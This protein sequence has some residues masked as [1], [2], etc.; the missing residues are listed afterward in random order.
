MLDTQA[1]ENSVF[2]VEPLR[3]GLSVVGH[4]FYIIPSIFSFEEKKILV[5]QGGLISLP[6]PPPPPQCV[7]IKNLFPPPPP[8]PLGG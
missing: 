5:V 7:K 3:S 6:P 1:H 8:P 4:I 2:V